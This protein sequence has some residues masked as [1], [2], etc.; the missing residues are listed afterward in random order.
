MPSGMVP[1]NG[2]ATAN[3][4][5]HRFP[6]PTG[7]T[8]A[9]IGT[10]QIETDLETSVRGVTVIDPERN[11]P[12]SMRSALATEMSVWQCDGDRK[13]SGLPVGAD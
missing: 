1:G 9:K 11:E 10:T 12:G 3:P 4:R 7:T 5:H 2:G 13:T 8:G 6:G